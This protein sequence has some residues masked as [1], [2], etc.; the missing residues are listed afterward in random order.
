M[1]KFDLLE[2][3]CGILRISILHSLWFAIFLYPVEHDEQCE[4]HSSAD[5]YEGELPPEGRACGISRHGTGT[6]AEPGELADP[7]QRG[8]R[9]RLQ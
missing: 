9:G 5:K 4:G 7:V 3:Y 2:L 8:D 1:H 6:S